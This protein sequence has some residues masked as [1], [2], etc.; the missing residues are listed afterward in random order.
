M[1]LPHIDN[2]DE[3]RQPSQIQRAGGL[4]VRKRRADRSK[5]NL[6]RRPGPARAA[7]VVAA[8]VCVLLPN[9][10]AGAV[11]DH[12]PP[13]GATSDGA[14]TVPSPAATKRVIVLLKDQDSATPDT[15]A[16][17]TSRQRSI[18]ASQEGVLSQLMATKA[19]RVH[20]D[21]LVNAVSATVSPAEADRLAADPDVAGV[22]PDEPIRITP[23]STDSS[24]PRSSTGTYT[25]VPGSCST[26]PSKPQLGPEAIETI[27]A[28][29]A[30]PSTPSATQLGYTGAGV[31]VAYI[32]N[33]ID[34]S[35]PD[36]IRADGTH[37]FTDYEDFTGEG[38][39]AQTSGLES[40]L[41]AS[42][43]AA[44]GRKVY[45]VANYYQESNAT[46]CYIQIRGVAPGASLVGLDAGNQDFDYTSELLEAIDWAVTHDHVN[47]L[48]ESIGGLAFPDTETAD[49][50]ARAD[51]AAVAAGVTV[52]VSSGDTGVYDTINS[53]ATDPNVLSVASTTT[54]RSLAQ[55]GSLASFTGADG[56]PISGWEDDN[57]S[58]LDS[59]GEDTAG[60]TVDL[61]APGDSN[62]ALCSPST[63]YQDCKDHR[64]NP[65]SVELVGGTSEAAPLTAGV[66]ALVI[67]A[68]RNA[69]GGT[70]PTPAEVKTIILSTADDIH[71][72]ADLAGAGRLDAYRAVLAAAA[73]GGAKSTHSGG[74]LL[75]GTPQIDKT[76]PAG[77]KVSVTEKV[78]NDS[79]T[80]QTVKP[81]TRAIGAYRSL[82]RTPMDLSDAGSPKFVDHHGLDVNYQRVTFGVPAG[83][84]HLVADLSFSAGS[85]ATVPPL[86]ALV[87]PHDHVAA[88]SF[89]AGIAISM[90][91]RSTLPSPV[92]GLPTSSLPRAASGG[93]TGSMLFGV[94]AAD[95]VT[96]GS[97][98]PSS[99]TIQPNKTGAVVYS[100]TAPSGP[101][102]VAGSVVMADGAET[103]SAP[104]IVRTLV[105]TGP[106]TF[107]GT[108]FGGNGDVGDA[109]QGA[110][111]QLNLPAGLPELNVSVTLGNRSV[112][113]FAAELV[114]PA[115]EAVASSCN[116]LDTNDTDVPEGGAVLHALK[117]AAGKWT[118]ALDFYGAAS[119]LALS[120]PYTVSVDEA[121][122]SVV[123][124][125]VPNSAST[126]LPSGRE[127]SFTVKIRN[128]DLDPESFFT[129]ARLP[130]SE[131]FHVP[132]GLSNAMLLP[133]VTRFSVRGAEARYAEASRRIGFADPGDSD[134]TAQVKLVNGLEALNRDLA[135]P[136][137]AAFG[138]NEAAWFGKMALMAD[139]A[140]ASGKFRGII[141][142][143]R[144][145]RKLSR[146]TGRFG[147]GR[148][149]TGSFAGETLSVGRADRLASFHGAW[150]CSGYG[151]SA[152]LQAAAD[153]SISR[154]CSLSVDYGGWRRPPRN[155]ALR[156][157]VRRR[158]RSNHL[159]PTRPLR[160]HSAS[161]YGLPTEGGPYDPS[162]PLFTRRCP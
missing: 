80:A 115:G 4:H 109:G 71:A 74:A 77:G 87:D 67:Q 31:K 37:V 122:R 28:D 93:V 90:T 91:F 12:A 60:R 158:E 108:L 127:S 104:V 78:T 160:R 51:D 25:S 103:A 95:W 44:Q 79:A 130:G 52:T 45:N 106:T 36:F 114:D 94:R 153:P 110:Y 149:R 11:P 23:T 161:A 100:V 6:A 35:N 131:H 22:V 96:L 66:A 42:S 76:L 56:H 99:L 57:T 3:S 133:A 24:A 121:S 123:T 40:F 148:R 8:A 129:D 155:V 29:A 135:V 140:L 107:A 134:A 34:T 156:L 7:A 120:T 18:H 141:H 144:G 33:G 26:N 5:G 85:D 63:Q 147:P 19:G 61:A 116:D 136:T 132:H 111:Y 72:L 27:R 53:P 89:D 68:F 86:I 39:G 125:D 47:V 10:M 162:R 84:A 62:W 143:C 159:Q 112:T 124:S 17:S 41:D 92:S 119:V 142:A 50:I 154:R 117:P 70:S 1:L 14:A 16:D 64:G 13:A 59:G 137:P 38:K 82:D 105:P 54:L 138:I 126:V 55:V 139:Q 101:G 46:P 30:T 128:A 88:Y 152:D 145:Q 102:D 81:A 21:T 97:V 65:S 58:S 48:N 151:W 150:F 113:A 83:V 69:H 43:I 9:Q 2:S 15:P 49:V 98:S 118:I 146:C 20:S 73:Y 157:S 32:A 75:L